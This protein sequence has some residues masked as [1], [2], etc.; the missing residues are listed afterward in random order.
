MGLGESLHDIRLGHF[1]SQ[2]SAPPKFHVTPLSARHRFQKGS[3]HQSSTRSTNSVL[4]MRAQDL[5]QINS[6]TSPKFDSAT[7][8]TIRHQAGISKL[9]R[10]VAVISLLLLDSTFGSGSGC[11]RASKSWARIWECEPGYGIWAALRAL[12]T[13]LH[14]D[15]LVRR[16]TH[17]QLVS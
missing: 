1:L 6:N 13:S 14:V 4:V 8:Q 5:C 10:S 15:R 9:K 3:V 17:E 11:C 16:D 2:P 7:R 12:F